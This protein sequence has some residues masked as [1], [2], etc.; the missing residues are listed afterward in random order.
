M[1]VYQVCSNKSPG[2]KIGPAPGDV[3][4]PYMCI[5]KTLKIFLEKTRIARVKILSMKH[6]LVSVYK[7]CSNK[8]PG[9]K[10][11]PAPGVSLFLNICVN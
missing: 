9:V 11:V 5:A 4:F 2:V 3:D 8:S 6:L 10:T 7:D 1:D